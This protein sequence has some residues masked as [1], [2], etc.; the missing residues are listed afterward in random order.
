MRSPVALAWSGYLVVALLL[1]VVLA[2][3][4]YPLVVGGGAV[5]LVI[6]IGPRSFKWSPRVRD[7]VIAVALY[8]ACVGLFSGAFQLVGPEAEM[9][10]FAFFAAGLLLGVLGPLA[11]VTW[12]QGRSL[13]DLGLTRARLPA[14]MALALV[15]AA[16]QAA[17]TFPMVRFGAPTEWLPLLALA[18][19]VGFFEAIFFRAYLV[20][21]FEPMFGL[22]P[23]VAIAAGLYAAYHVGYGMAVDEMLFLAGLGLVYTIAFAVTRNLF[24]LWPLLTP[25][26]SFFSTVRGGEITMPMISILGFVD[27]LAVMCVAAYLAW[28]WTRRRPVTRVATPEPADLLVC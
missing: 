15:L 4:T 24:V 21:V 3:P 26:G 25:L 22:V 8:A 13:A 6:A 14:T 9:G 16:A 17:I 10:L 2:G 28:R 5:L 11:H 1:L 19:T 12:L 23:A 27:V 18:I 7:A 20:A